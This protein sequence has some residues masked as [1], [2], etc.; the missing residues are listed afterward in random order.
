V[1]CTFLHDTQ[2]RE[3]DGGEQCAPCAAGPHRV[4]RLVLPEPQVPRIL[5]PRADGKCNK[6]DKEK[7]RERERDK[8][9]CVHRNGEQS[10]G[11]SRAEAVRAPETLLKA[12]EE[13]RSSMISCIT[14]LDSYVK[15]STTPP[16]GAGES[17]EPL[18][19]ALNRH[20]A[21]TFNTSQMLSQPTLVAEERIR[22]HGTTSKGLL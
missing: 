16:T 9:T 8:G 5:L 4:R 13:A 12:E 2:Q 11:V 7:E 22:M 19:L 14:F 1:C 3:Q 10:Q 21:L 15:S 18:N 20:S 6:R 17:T